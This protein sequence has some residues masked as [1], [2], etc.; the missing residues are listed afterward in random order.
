MDFNQ[1]VFTVNYDM[2]GFPY[3]TTDILAHRVEESA[4]LTTSPNGVTTKLFVNSDN[5]LRQWCANGRSL[6]IQSFDNHEDARQEWLM[7]TYTYDYINSVLWAYDYITYDNALLE[8]SDKMELDEDVVKS[9]L[10]HHELYREMEAKK[11][12][13]FIMYRYYK[14]VENSKGIITKKVVQATNG[15][16]YPFCYMYGRSDPYGSPKLDVKKYYTEKFKEDIKQTH[17][18]M[19]KG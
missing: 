10:R 16:L 5:E 12:A 13:A 7:R 19:K 2:K 18:Q 6:L 8:I 11:R 4:E 15:A 17:S 3:I 14:A 9:L 1:K